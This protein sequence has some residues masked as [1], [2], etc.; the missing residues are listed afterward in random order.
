MSFDTWWAELTGEAK[1]VGWDLGDKES[2][3]DYYDDE[4]SP[5]YALESE[6]RRKD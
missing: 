5:E 4:D 2:Y 1:R 3:R 6:M